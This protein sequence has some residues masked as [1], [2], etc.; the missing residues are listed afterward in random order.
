MR[1]AVTGT[2][3]RVGAALAR[4]FSDAGHTVIHLPR[5]SFDLADPTAMRRVLRDLDVDVFLHPAGITSVDAAEDDPALTFRINTTAAAEI[6]TWAAGKNIRMVYFSTDYV[7]GGQTPGLRTEDETPAPL[8]TYGASKLAG[9]QAVLAAS[10]NHLVCR[11]SWVFGPEKPSFVDQIVANATAG[12]PLTAIADKFSLPTSTAAICE[13]ISLLLQT[14]ATGIFHLCHP[15]PPVSW[16]TL[17][18]FTIETLIPETPRTPRTT[19]TPLPLHQASGFRAPRP[20]FTAMSTQKLQ[21]HI[22]THLPLTP[23]PD[24]LKTYLLTQYPR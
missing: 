9:E 10:P 24:A 2:T 7:F 17:A 1:I 21:T 4:R 20:Q 23:W 15:G 19:I 6:A 8:G 16:H 13:W 11:V 22:G 14:Q 18:E 12:N 3:G 5:S